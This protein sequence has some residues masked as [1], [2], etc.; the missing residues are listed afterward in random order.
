MGES[1]LKTGI[2]EG[3]HDASLLN[4]EAVL[5]QSKN[6]ALLLQDKVTVSLFITC[7]DFLFF[8]NL[9]QIT[10]CCLY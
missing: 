1:P 2:M 9:K 8:P 3:V 7:R 4:S 5:M 6:Y 10:L